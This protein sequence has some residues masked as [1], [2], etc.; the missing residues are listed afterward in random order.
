M[1]YTINETVEQVGKIAIQGNIIPNEWYAHLRNEKGKI[2]TNAALI[3]ADIVYWYRP[4]PTY[5]IK[6][7]EMVGY[8]KK[9][10]DDLLQLNYK[11]FNK[12]F[13]FSEIQSRNALIFLENK[14]LIFREFRATKIG[15]YLLNNVMYIG[16]YPEK[17]SS[18]TQQTDHSLSTSIP[19]MQINPSTLQTPSIQI[20]SPQFKTKEKDWSVKFSD[21]QKSFLNYLLNIQP[22][23][24]DPIEKNHATWWI[25]SF[26]IEKIQT[27]L[28]V[29]WERVERAKLDPAVPMPQHMGKYMCTALNEDLRPMG[30][31][32]CTPYLEKSKQV[33]M[34]MRRHIQIYQ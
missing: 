8:G 14:G 3:L 25:K 27:A 34:K 24:G 32:S 6:T 4:I 1:I 12:K 2:Q 7:S 10:K 30:S 26:G 33:V 29:Y 28:Q 21:E 23:M 15:S 17:I 20:E 16:I 5:D 22:E 18:I 9:F 13:G 19:E 11:Y 31:N